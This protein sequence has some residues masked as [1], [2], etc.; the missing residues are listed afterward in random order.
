MFFYTVADGKKNRINSRSNRASLNFDGV[1]SSRV[2]KVR[3]GPRD[4]GRQKFPEVHNYHQSSQPD[5]SFIPSSRDRWQLTTFLYRKEY[6]LLPRCCL[7]DSPEISP[8]AR[9]HFQLI[10]QKRP[11]SAEAA[12]PFV[13]TEIN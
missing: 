11:K 10:D 2:R 4:S 8:L 9:Q 12:G 6:S 5:A 1:F 13:A 3:G 7:E